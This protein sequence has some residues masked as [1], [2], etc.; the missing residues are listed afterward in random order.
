MALGNERRRVEDVWDDWEV[1]GWHEHG[2]A[3][4]RAR[5]CDARHPVSASSRT[6]V[7]RARATAARLADRLPVLS[8]AYRFVRRPSWQFEIWR[9]LVETRRRTAFLRRLPA[10][11]GTA[12][13][14][15]AMVVLYRDDIYETKTAL[16]LASA[17]QLQGI[18]PV[19]VA[20]AR[21]MARIRWYARAFG[22]DGF[23]PLDDLALTP[24]ERGECD[25][26]VD[27]A[28]PRSFAEL[29]ELTFRGHQLGTHVLSTVIRLLVDGAPDLSHPEVRRLTDGVVAEVA[30]TY[31]RSE[32]LID[33]LH[34]RLVLVEEANYSR[35]GPVVD[36]AVARGIDVVQTTAVWRDDALVSKRLVAATRRVDAKSVDRQT[37]G[38]R[39]AEPLSPQE[40]A[41]LDADFAARYGDTWTLTR[42]W[43]PDNEY[44]APDRLAEVL[45]VDP[46]RPTA[47]VFAHVLWDA[48]LFFGTDL[49]DNYGDW[50]VRTVGAAIDNPRFNWVVKAHP[51]NVFRASRGDVGGGSQEVVLLQRH[52]PSLPDH[53]RVLPAATPVSALSVYEFADVGLTVRGTP[54]LEMAC[55]GKQVLTAG[56]GHYSGFGFTTDSGT[57][58]EHLTRVR[59]LYRPVPLTPEEADRA[60]RYAH[61]L[62]CRRPWLVRSFSTDF[63]IDRPGWRPLDRNV[64]VRA[65]SVDDIRSAGDLLPWSEW[66]LHS[67]AIDFIQADERPGSATP[68]VGVARS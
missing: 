7:G 27:A 20:P 28:H 16:V 8:E 49:F 63:K 59:E 6:D 31:V 40:Q 1:E 48:S 14:D 60:R 11:H 15:P 5:A 58:D 57:A 3:Q 30:A 37:L 22:I 67:D 53:V 64:T 29:K 25:T 54:G 12:G 2:T 33:A 32:R 61:T 50:L 38:D 46:G 10:R 17:L 55:F 44:V 47:V 13:A 35:N 24:A 68:P 21:R 65:R 56:T 45:G 62:F 26:V 36:V 51:S 4:H 9:D 18:T 41:E 52:F 23:V 66:A 34:P 43:Q 39:A 19:I 42:Q